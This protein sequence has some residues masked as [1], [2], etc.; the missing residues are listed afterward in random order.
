M[1]RHLLLLPCLMGLALPAAADPWALCEPQSPL[2]QSRP[3]EGSEERVRV[4]ADQARLD[5]Q[6]RMH[7]EGEV[8]IHQGR[9]SL[10]ADQV[11][12]DRSSGIAIAR[13]GVRFSDADGF[14]LESTG[15]YLNLE[16]QSGRFE[17]GRYRYLPRHARGAARVIAPRGDNRFHLEGAT[18]TTCDPGRQDWLLSASKVDLD[19]KS[20]RGTARNVLLRFHHVPLL[21]TPWIDFPIDDRRQSGLLLPSFGNANNTGLD[22]VI[23]YYLNLAPNRDATIAP[24]FIGRRGTML[25]TEFRYLEPRGA[26]EMQ[27]D[28][29]PEDRLE[30]D[31]RSYVS[32]EHDWTLTPRLRFHTE[33]ADVSDPNYFDDLGS[34]LNDTSS[35]HL[36]RRA[37]LRYRGGNWN[38]T[39]RVEDFQSL[40]EY[41]SPNSKPYQRLP[42]LLYRGH[43]SNLPGQANLDLQAEWVAFERE[44]SVTAR[45]TDLEP[46]LSLP[47]RGP[48]WFLDPKLSYRFTH[49]ALEDAPAQTGDHLQRE[50]PTFSLDGGLFFERS[51]GGEYLQLLEPRIFYTYTPYRDQDTIPRFDTSAY[52]FSFDQLFR[53]ARFSG[54]D[55]VADGNRLTTA[56]T[57]R[58]IDPA[59]AEELLRARLGQIHYLSDQRVRLTPG[60]APIDRAHSSLVGELAWRPAPGWRLNAAAQW[61]P[62]RER[63]ERGSVQIRYRDGGRI[64]N[65][66]H[67]YREDILRQG[68][69]SFAWPLSERWSAVGRW[70]YSLR[71]ER[72]LEELVGLEYQSCCWGARVVSR[73]YLVDGVENKY[74]NGIYF[75]IIFKGLTS[76]GSGVDELLSEGILGYENSD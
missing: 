26:G 67:R 15:G 58:I 9:R 76:L 35:T 63:T 11:I 16:D 74:S 5:Q 50:L 20:G 4:L 57:T 48:A 28:Y 43:W 29:L 1:Y 12:Y 24:R 42:Q 56:I 34:S 68:D 69:L 44:D 10:W 14:L 47:L 65:L 75:Q 21:Y 66:S 55:R 8:E 71:D 40:D 41:L 39:A 64:L 27:V 72:D 52:D 25:K 18:F 62:Q 19:Q 33:G 13:G 61:D 22:L 23:P 17:Q 7:L 6:G 37:D 53:S 70:A 32:W 36:Q 51:L 46:T 45:R 54:P 73:R 31:D 2:P 49:Y 38:L 60:L 59:T 30:G 3:P